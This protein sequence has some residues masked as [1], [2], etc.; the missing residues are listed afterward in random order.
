MRRL[1]TVAM[2]CAA[3]GIG[4]SSG[5]YAESFKWASQGDILTFDPHAQNE[6]FNNAAASYVYDSLVRYGKDGKIEPALAESW[7]TV[8]EGF[9]LRFRQGVKFH[10]V[11]H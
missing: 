9:V 5:A 4:I 10:E 7:K 1:V 8:P 11:R 3:L 6:S 2:A